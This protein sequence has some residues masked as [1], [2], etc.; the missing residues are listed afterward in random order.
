MR[1]LMKHK[2]KAVALFLI[3][4]LV[5]SQAS[6]PDNLYCCLLIF[7]KKRQNKQLCEYSDIP[8]SDCSNCF[9]TAHSQ[10]ISFSETIKLYGPVVHR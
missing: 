4:F 5:A 6:A 1:I 9:L 8:S 3:S 7:Q 2:V 10:D